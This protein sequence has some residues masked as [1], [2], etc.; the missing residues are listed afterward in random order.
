M[1]RDDLQRLITLIVSELSAAQ[2]LR[3]TRCA[4]HAVT[5]ECCPNRLQGVIDESFARNEA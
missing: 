1:T 3:A 5:S 2:T 4:C